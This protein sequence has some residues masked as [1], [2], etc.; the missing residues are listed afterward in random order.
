MTDTDRD[1][2]VIKEA[3]KRKIEHGNRLY[4]KHKNRYERRLKHAKTEPR[5]HN[6]P[7]LERL[8]AIWEGIKKSGFDFN[9]MSSEERFELLDAVED[10][11][12][13]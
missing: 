6:V 7:E 4:V 11:Y 5:Y 3:R 1:R 10:E 2:D 12:E 8:L 9:K 13:D